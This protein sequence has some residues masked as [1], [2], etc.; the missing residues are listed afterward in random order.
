L[1]GCGT[2]IVEVRPYQ[3][4]NTVQ[5]LPSDVEKDRQNQKARPREGPLG[6]DSHREGKTAENIRLSPQDWTT[7]RT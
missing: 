1:A 5:G 2:K 7:G 3:A 4:Q 6:G